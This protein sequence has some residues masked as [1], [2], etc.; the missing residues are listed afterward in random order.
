[1]KTNF[2]FIKVASAVPQVKVADCEWNI[3]QIE[4]L[5]SEA[6][7]NGAS[8]IV[9]PELCITGY[10]CADLFQSQ[11]LLDQTLEALNDVVEYT[12]TE[13]RLTTILGAP[14]RIDN[15]LFNCAIVN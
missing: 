8:V 2:G 4:Q 15:Q 11:L 1:M 9:F 14:L 13:V 5:M 7:E 6:N 10:T 12:K 3:S